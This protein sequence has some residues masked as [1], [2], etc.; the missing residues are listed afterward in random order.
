M[1]H[2]ENTYKFIFDECFH[3]WHYLN[4]ENDKKQKLIFVFIE[5]S[6]SST[7]V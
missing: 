6:S 2:H 3:F 5:N 1:L 4:I 7:Q